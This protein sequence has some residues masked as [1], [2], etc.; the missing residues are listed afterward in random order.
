MISTATS[1]RREP[2]ARP[3][4]KPEL[5][6]AKHVAT[7]NAI[8]I[9]DIAMRIVGALAYQAMIHSGAGVAAWGDRAM[10]KADA[11]PPSSGIR[12]GSVERM[13]Q[14]R[15]RSNKSTGPRGVAK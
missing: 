10:A 11:H 6:L 3:S 15:I 4:M 7:N 1:R 12:G 2:E 14:R 5:G 13:G 9:V 8:R